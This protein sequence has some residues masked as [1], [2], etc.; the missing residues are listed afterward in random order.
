METHVKVISDFS[1]YFGMVL[2]V[3]E[4]DK[5]FYFLKCPTTGRK[6][7]F[8]KREVELLEKTK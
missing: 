2:E 6:M 7:R 4:K 1:A 3:I 8:A 5:E